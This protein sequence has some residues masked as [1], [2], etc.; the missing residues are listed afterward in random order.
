MRTDSGVQ[1]ALEG[2]AVTVG[3]SPDNTIASPDERISRKHA[4]FE[5]IGGGWVVIDLGSANGTRVDGG[6]IRPGTPIPVTP[7]MTIGIG[8]LELDV[9]A[10]ASAGRNGAA[11]GTRA[12]GQAE[13][14]RISQEVLGL[15]GTGTPRSR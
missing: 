8:P 11:A 15:P 14:N 12:L 2:T 6:R 5:P 4:R 7:G 9:V 3:R 10:L 13:R 1:V